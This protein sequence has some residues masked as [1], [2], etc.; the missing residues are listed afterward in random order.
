MNGDGGKSRTLLFAISFSVAYEC[1]FSQ[2]PSAVDR[3]LYCYN[4]G[5]KDELCRV[6]TLELDDPGGRGCLFHDAVSLP[7][8]KRCLLLCTRYCAIAVTVLTL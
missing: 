5:L 3:P 4:T 6:E 7:S 8:F 2:L 1:F